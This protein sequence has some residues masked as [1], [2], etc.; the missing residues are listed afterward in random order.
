MHYSVIF[1]FF[2]SVWTNS[3]HS[4][5]FTKID[6]FDTPKIG[7]VIGNEVQRNLPKKRKFDFR[8]N[9]IY[10]ITLKLHILKSKAVCWLKMM[11]YKLSQF[12]PSKCGSLAEV[13]MRNNSEIVQAKRKVT[14]MASLSVR[15]PHLTSPNTIEEQVEEGEDEKNE[16]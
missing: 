5:N 4:V 6:I 8:F 13:F 15:L 3:I 12:I 9:F 16:P 2:I 7:T 10:K 14:H 1:D 11:L